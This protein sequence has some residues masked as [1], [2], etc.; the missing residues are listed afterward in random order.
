MSM[1]DKTGGR[2]TVAELV[3]DAI[4]KNPLTV[5]EIC[6]VT[7]MREMSVRKVLG[8]AQKFGVIAMNIDPASG[9]FRYSLTRLK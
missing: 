6:D 9:L 8:V 4:K 3:R 7:G 2:L 1:N 5:P